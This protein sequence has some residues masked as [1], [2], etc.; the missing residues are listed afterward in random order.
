MKFSVIVHSPNF[1][2]MQEDQNKGKTQDHDVD[3]HNRDEN[4]KTPPGSFTGTNID[5]YVTG[6]ISKNP[7]EQKNAA[8]AEGRGE[9]E[10]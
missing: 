10:Q 5:R 8:P 1:Q 9:Q 4:E 7:E 6:E 3:E 2:I